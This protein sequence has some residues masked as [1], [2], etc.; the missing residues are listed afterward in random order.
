M[1]AGLK[2]AKKWLLQYEFDWSELGD[3]H[4]YTGSASVIGSFLSSHQ[5]ERGL[6]RRKK[7]VLCFLLASHHRSIDLLL[8]SL[9][10][11]QSAREKY[12]LDV[13]SCEKLKLR[14][15]NKCFSVKIMLHL[16]P[17]FSLVSLQSHEM[18]FN[19]LL[20]VVT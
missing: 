1:A 5:I 11:A 7:E 10:S 2:R 6:S 19:L 14:P 18:N 8:F 3:K 20:P 16:F 17:Q 13:L 9:L 4:R 12:F 15:Q